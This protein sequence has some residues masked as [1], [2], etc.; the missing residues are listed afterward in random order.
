M[1]ADAR[2][3]PD[4]DPKPMAWVSSG[5]S[6]WHAAS[7]SARLLTPGDRGDGGVRPPAGD[8]PAFHVQDLEAGVPQH[9]TLFV[10]RPVIRRSDRVIEGLAGIALEEANKQAP[11]WLQDTA[12]LHDGS[13]QFC[14]GEM[15]K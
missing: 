12:K 5:K 14:G 3:L 15:N 1:T 7:V 2:D 8:L 13:G 9:R 6:A 11:L 10:H 4:R